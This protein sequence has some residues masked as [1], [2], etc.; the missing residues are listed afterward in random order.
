MTQATGGTI[1]YYIRNNV[2]YKVHTF[3]TSS[4]LTVTETGNIDIL[5]VAGGGAGHG[6]VGG[7]G[8][9]GGLLYQTNLSIASNL[10]ITIGAGSTGAQYGTTQDAANSAAGGNTTVTG[11]GVSLT[12]VGGGSGGGYSDSNGSAG[13]SG[14]GVGGEQTGGGTGGAA[15]G[16]QGNRGGNSVSGRSGNATGGGGGGGA[17]AVG[18]NSIGAGTTTAGSG[19]AGKREG[20]DFF[21][22]GS[23]LWYAGGGGG[24]MFNAGTAVATGGNGGAG[25]GGGGGAFGSVSTPGAGGIGRNT[26]GIG[27]G[28]DTAGRGGDGGANT[29]GGGGGVGHYSTGTNGRAGSGGSGIVIVRYSFT[30]TG[31]TATRNSATLTLNKYATNT[32]TAPVTGTSG[33]NVYSYSIS[34]ALPTGL[35]INTSTGAIVGQPQTAVT[36]VTYTVTVNDG[37]ISESNTFSLTTTTNLATSIEAAGGSLGYY[38]NSTRN[39]IYK[40]HTFTSAGNLVVTTPGTITI[41]A[42]GGGGGGG[43][44][45]GSGAGGAGAFVQGDFAASV[46]S[47]GI[48]AGGGGLSRA[49]D[50]GPGAAPTGGGGL[51]GN[52]GYGGQGG[53]YSGFFA[54]TTI[55]QAGAL[56]IAGGGGGG[57]WEGRAGGAA[58]IA[59]GSPGQDGT[60]YGGRGGSQTAGGYSASGA[61][62]A[63][64]GGNIA[65]QGD[66]GGGGGG[67]AGYFGGGGGTSDGTGSGGG[68]GSS[69]FAGNITTTTG[70]AGSGTIS[71]GTTSALY[72]GW[73]IGGASGANNGN[74][75]AVIVSYPFEPSPLITTVATP[76]VTLNRWTNNGGVTPITVTGGLAP[77]YYTVSPAVPAGLHFNT[78]TGQI[79]GQ[80]ITATAS[81]V[82]TV[83][84]RDSTITLLGAPVNSA[85]DTFTLTTTITLPGAQTVTGGST[86]TTSANG[87][88]YQVHTFTSSGNLTLG[89]TTTLEYLAVAGGGGGGGRHGGGGG[90]GGLVTGTIALPAG[91]YPIIVGAGGSGAQTDTQGIDGVDS[92]IIQSL[93]HGSGEFDGRSSYIQLANS[94]ALALNG[95]SWTIECWVMPTGDYSGQG[96]TIFSKRVSGATTT[97][98][99][100]Y[101]Q[102]T[103]GFVGYYNGT[104]ELTSSTV[105]TPRVWSHIAWVYNGTNIRIFVNGVSVLNTATAVSEINEPLVIGGTRG[106]NAWFHGYISNLRIVKGTT[107]YTAD[108]TPPIGPL[109]AISGTSLL[110][111]QHPTAWVDSSTNAAAITTSGTPVQSPFNPFNNLDAS[112]GGGG[113]S[114]S[115]N[116]PTAGRVGGSGGGGGTSGAAGGAAWIG[117]GN[118]GGQGNND[119]GGGGGGAGTPGQTAVGSVYAGAGGTGAISNIDGLNY[120]Y[121]GGGGGGSWQQIAGAGGLGGGGGGGGGDT[122][123]TNAGAGG[124]GG[125]TNGAAGVAG[126]SGNVNGGAGGANTG[127][128]GGSSGQRD[129]QSYT[130]VGGNGG[131][132]III[133]RYIT[134]PG[135]LLTS[136]VIPEVLFGKYDNTPQIPVAPIGGTAPYTY[137]ISPSLPDGVLFS[138]GN[139]AVYGT[140]SVAVYD[141]TYTVSITDS[142]ATPVTATN[143]FVLSTSVSYQ[144]AIDLVAN[145]LLKITTEYGIS[146]T[147]RRSAYI[148]SPGAQIITNNL[149][150]NNK[151][152]IYGN[153][154]SVSSLANVT[155]G[156]GPDIVTTVTVPTTFNNYVNVG[157]NLKTYYGNIVANVSGF[158]L[159][160]AFYGT[161]GSYTW[162][163]P[164]GVSSISVAGVGG[165]GGGS[166]KT[167]GGSGGGGGQ[168]T[169][170]NNV[171]VTPGDTYTIVIG[172]G[173]NTG[174]NFG[175]SGG[176]T[177]MFKNTGNTVPILLATGGRGGDSMYWTDTSSFVSVSSSPASMSFY[178]FRATSPLNQTITYSFSGP[179]PG[180]VTVN[181]STGVLGGVPET[182]GNVTNYPI[183]V[184]AVTTAQTITKP[185]TLTVRPLTEVTYV[186]IGGNTLGTAT[187][188]SFTVLNTP[189]VDV[190]GCAGGGSTIAPGAEPGAGG[191]GGGASQLNGYRLTVTPG[192]TLTYSIGSYG[193]PTTISRGGTVIFQLNAGSSTTNSTGGAGGTANSYSSHAGGAGANGGGRFTG[194]STASNVTGCAGGGGGGGYGDNSPYTLGGAGGNGGTSSVPA[195]SICIG[196][197]GGTGGARTNP[198]TRGGNILLA[199]GGRVTNEGWQGM[200]GGAGGGIKINA[201]STTNFYGGGAGGAGAVY[202]ANQTPGG[203]GC[204]YVYWN[205]NS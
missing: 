112:G 134:G 67:G 122:A 120:Y 133:V 20:V 157:G 184:S 139:G 27:Q 91:T 149:Q 126:F 147:D 63:L 43:W 2:A 14:G 77:Y 155:Y 87:L 203:P 31:L 49:N 53:G 146:D 89:Q 93:Q 32:S 119:E 71:G 138:S 84:V 33:S 68:G 124:T 190:W 159:S 145:R 59:V 1:S 167:T 189:F 129:F 132:G 188:G 131:S 200:G 39:T 176:D 37:F 164:A 177:Y 6:Y 178:T 13:G 45:A 109:T 4:T 56:L 41:S 148:E 5:A 10:T 191:G 60:T 162:T 95:V 57:G 102:A 173:G 154:L 117:Q 179:L 12:A 54:T 169:Y 40:T 105:L 160:N 195:G 115:S 142:S 7:G 172:T 50:V 151:S 143:T 30:P 73:G 25:G 86:S 163:V 61:G 186:A 111:L 130:G 202:T 156:I 23:G 118:A 103:T 187:T 166:Q 170:I 98:Y 135:Q 22:D 44:T 100:G 204:L 96:R 24:G 123:T 175:V 78:S 34:P 66:G 152:L 180:N 150:S 62:S 114:Y 42:W 47:Y 9:A 64:Q 127:G 192:E 183:T 97:A 197:I 196:S 198:P 38:Y 165:G 174:S 35:S 94:T 171:P 153:V 82:Y 8:G 80:P 76:S 46:A 58:G 110:T 74:P 72:R 19:G 144:Y 92:G 28:S 116:A 140:P 15:T 185:F 141:A 161:A 3:T 121:A 48:V 75:G 113:G 79:T 65:A 194:G 52:A 29:G 85:I 107:L 11:T 26:G 16:S 168:L 70:E 108:F 193:Q 21:I 17:G 181:S 128:G 104:T 69:Y 182:V 158:F 36:G 201:I 55:N 205:A 88:N 106:Y 81:T 125:R 90:G 136:K 99:Y 137:S 51:P 83:T 101:L 18:G 199:E